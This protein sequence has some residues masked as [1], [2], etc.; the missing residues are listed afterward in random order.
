MS[1]VTEGYMMIC[2][3]Q[4]EYSISW[5]IIMFLAGKNM[6]PRLYNSVRLLCNSV[7]TENVKMHTFSQN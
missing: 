2:E 3:I 6:K 5:Q 4:G 7:K 1:P